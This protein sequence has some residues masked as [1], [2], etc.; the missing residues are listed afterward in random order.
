MNIVD[1]RHV[2]DSAKPWAD[3]SIEIYID[4]DGSRKNRYDGWNDFQLTYR[5]HDQRLTL[6]GRTPK[7]KIHAVKHRMVKLANG[8]QLETTIPWTTLNV[9]PKHGH[10]VGFDIQVNDDDSGDQ[11]DA[12]LAWNAQSDQAWKNP[13]MFGQLVL[14][15]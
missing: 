13:Q 7:N 6:G 1:D 14:S 15:N 11:R 8:Y 3:D 5:L 9:R 10:V 4:A 2:R 12:K